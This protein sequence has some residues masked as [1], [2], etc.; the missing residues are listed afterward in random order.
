M[1]VKQNSEIYTLLNNIVRSFD[2]VYRSYWKR[3]N[4]WTSYKNNWIEPGIE[5]IFNIRIDQ[6]LRSK[7]N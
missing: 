4:P 3:I 2:H 5:Y 6:F 7:L 1:Y